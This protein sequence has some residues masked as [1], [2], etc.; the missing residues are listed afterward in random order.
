[1]GIEVIKG[2]V[3]TEVRVRGG[4]FNDR[5][6]F[7]LENGDEWVMEHCQDC[8]ETVSIHEI[9]GDLQSLVGQTVDYASSVS[10][11][12]DDDDDYDVCQSGTVTRFSINTRNGLVV[13]TWHG[14]SN[15]YYSEGVSF[16]KD[17]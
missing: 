5:I 7:T 4:E 13:V 3:I 9:Y 16:Y 15:G 10:G 12:I 14:F 17:N 6:V 2:Q 8:C 11:G 1:M